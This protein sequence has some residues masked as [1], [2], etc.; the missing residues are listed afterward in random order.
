MSGAD[1]SRHG[2][3]LVSLGDGREREGLGNLELARRGDGL[4]EAL[5]LAPKA[6]RKAENH[7]TARKHLS[8]LDERTVAIRIVQQV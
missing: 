7:L 8:R 2:G 3:C 6:R 4:E 5:L 1:R